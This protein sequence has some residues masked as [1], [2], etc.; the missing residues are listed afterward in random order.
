MQEPFDAY[1][2]LHYLGQRL[3][4][5]LFVCLGAGALALIVSLLLPKEY[6]ATTSVLIDVPAGNDLRTSI[7]V[8]PVYLESLRAYELFAS[9]DTLFLRA[10]E[11]FHLRD[12]QSP[13]PIESEKRRILK[14]TKLRDTK[15]LQIAVTLPDPKQAL[16][17]AQ[18][19]A[20]ELVTLSRTANREN[21]RDLLDDAQRVFE[22]ARKRLEE[23]Q[24]AW[25]EFSVREPLD[26]LRGE[27]ETQNALIQRLRRDLSDSRAEVAELTGRGDEARAAGV[28]ARVQ[29]LRETGR[30]T[31]TPDGRHGRATLATRGARRRTAAEAAVRA[32]CL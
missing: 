15:I 11:K 5:I 16:A 6:T 12:P 19:L 24:T 23:E 22:E 2:F 31:S 27:I 10:L 32:D 3:R 26:A 28:R 14:V 21:D 20:D 1:Q 4:F 18:F 17:L 25:R 9:S 30:R 7:A 29:S 13:S 8:S